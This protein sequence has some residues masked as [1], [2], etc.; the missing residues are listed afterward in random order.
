MSSPYRYVLI[1]WINCAIERKPPV[2]LPAETTLTTPPQSLSISPVC[3]KL[4][5]NHE[6]RLDLITLVGL[7][8]RGVGSTHPTRSVVCGCSTLYLY[9]DPGVVAQGIADPLRRWPIPWCT[10]PWGRHRFLLLPPYIQ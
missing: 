8:A 4:A 7:E 6:T 9:P 2:L 3:W 1:Y 5:W 10:F